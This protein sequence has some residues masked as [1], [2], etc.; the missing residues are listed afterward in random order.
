MKKFISMLLILILCFTLEP[1]A[2][3]ATVKLNIKSAVVIEGNY[4]YLTLE[5]T[6]E[7][8]KWTSSNEYLASVSSK[9]KVTT[10]GMGHV[11][12]T[13]KVGKKKYVCKVLVIPNIDP[14][15]K[16]DTDIERELAERKYIDDFSD[17]TLDDK[18][19]VLDENN[20]SKNTADSK[21]DSEQRII[22]MA[23][24]GFASSEDMDTELGKAYLEFCATWVS[25]SE[26]KYYGISTVLS[27]SDNR[28]YIIIDTK[29]KYILENTPNKFTSGKVYT[30]S[31]VQYQYLEKFEYNGES[32]T[33]NQFFFSR[34]DLIKKGIE[35]EKK[36]SK[37]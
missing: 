3:A 10:N 18:T 8:V 1:I 17:D 22:E 24:Y 36:E 19:I 20:E 31:G 32:F 27:L 23:K 25:E 26:L 34:A 28:I 9:G 13:A 12:I 29:N 5:G 6:K 21:K 15:Y 16:T 7:T 14:N 30:T 35:V 37:K 4:L 33:K 2:N 11:N